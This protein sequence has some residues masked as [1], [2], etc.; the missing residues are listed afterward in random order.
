MQINCTYT[1]NNTTI[2]VKSGSTLDVGGTLKFSVSSKLGFFEPIDRINTW[3]EVSNGGK[4]IDSSHQ[5]IYYKSKKEDD[6]IFSFQR[7]LSYVG[8]HLLRCRVY[9][10]RKGDITKIFCINAK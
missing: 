7:E 8:R 9:N 6:S 3:W 5:E 10:V 2:P 4:E 1:H